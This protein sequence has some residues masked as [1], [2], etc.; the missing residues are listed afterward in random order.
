MSP[1]L[2][3]DYFNMKLCLAHPWLHQACLIY[4]IGSLPK[5]PYQS[6]HFLNSIHIYIKLPEFC[7]SL[8][9]WFLSPSHVIPFSYLAWKRAPNAHSVLPAL[10]LACAW[11]RQLSTCPG[12]PTSGCLR[13]VKQFSLPTL[14]S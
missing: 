11:R 3:D 1:P 8:A 7:S 14:W 2:I 12:L 13:E 6:Y 9:N 10:G 4:S 5:K